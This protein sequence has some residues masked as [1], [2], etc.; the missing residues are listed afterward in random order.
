MRVLLVHQNFPGQFKH[1][2][3]ALVARGDEVVAL[4]MNAPQPM[5][6]VDIHSAP[7]KSGTQSTHLWTQEMETK[8]LRAESAFTRA[9]A[10]RDAGFSPDVIVGHPAWGDMLF[11][12][13]VWPAARLGIYCEFFYGLDG[14]DSGF[15]REFEDVSQGDEN[16]ARIK[17]KTLPQ[18]LHFPIANAGLSPTHFQA[19]TYPSSFRDRITVVHD[20]IDTDVIKPSTGVSLKL[21]SGLEVSAKDEIITFVSRNLEPYRGYHVFMRALPELQRRRPN[22]R[23]FIIGADGV[24][25]GARPETGTW[26][27][28]FLSEVIERLDMSRVHFV[29]ALAY[30]LFLQLLSISRLHVYLTYPFVLSW[31]LMEAMAIGAPIL[32]S[33]TA[34]LQEVIRH[35]ENGLLFPFF[36]QTA[37]VDGAERILG[38]AAL[39]EQ[40]TVNARR[41]IIDEYDLK[42]RC[43]PR[44]IAWIDALAAMEAKPALFEE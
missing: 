33:D 13:E 24:S 23:I 19:N 8:L 26:K 38:D 27:Q 25:Y 30:P 39:R 31:S 42:T 16:R 4:T 29:G 7:P 44:Q 11:L 41:T 37:L 35:G 3:P 18:R 40:L 9:I 36:D 10:I 32:G 20:G 17:L 43:L 14:L 6:G 5:A 1:L 15:D 28:H 21:G 22:A 12:K 2:A 34:P